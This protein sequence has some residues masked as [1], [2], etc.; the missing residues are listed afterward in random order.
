MSSPNSRILIIVSSFVFRCVNNY[1]VLYGNKLVYHDRELILNILL[2][3][4]ISVIELLAEYVGGLIVMV[5][6]NC[7][8][9]CSCNT[10][11]YRLADKA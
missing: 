1:V 7:D 6:R 9:Y 5:T 2:N 8:G 3:V 10:N 11:L 4:R